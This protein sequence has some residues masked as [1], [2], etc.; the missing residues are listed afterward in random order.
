MKTLVSV[1][2]TNFRSWLHT[3]FQ[4]TDGQHLIV[5][6][7]GTGKSSLLLAVYWCLY[8]KLPHSV[9]ADEVIHEP[10]G[11]DT[12]VTVTLMD[13]NEEYRIT[14]YRKHRTWKNK[15]VIVRDGKR[16]GE[17]D[18]KV[19]SIDDAIVK[20]VGLTA[21]EFLKVVYFSQRDLQRFPALTDLQQKQLLESLTELRVIPNV[22]EL[23]KARL[24]T[25]SSS[26]D[27]LHDRR[28]QHQEALRSYQQ[29]IDQYRK[30]SKRRQENI[31]SEIRHYRSKLHD[32]HARI[33]AC[34]TDL[35]AITDDVQRLEETIVEHTA[36]HSVLRAAAKK[37]T[38][39][40]EKARTIAPGTKCHWCTS[41]LTKE[42]CEAMVTAI[43]AELSTLT[44]R[45]ATASE[46][47]KA[48]QRELRIIDQKKL[49]RELEKAKH[50]LVRYRSY[51][52][53]KKRELVT[54]T[55][56]KQEVDTSAIEAVKVKLQKTKDYQRVLK[57]S[58][59]HV[60]L[61]LVKMKQIRGQMLPQILDEL[62]HRIN[63][64]IAP[65]KQQLE[66]FYREEKGRIRHSYRRGKKWVSYRSLSGGQQQIVDLASSFATWGLTDVSRASAFDCVFLDE[67]L[68]GL[69]PK[70]TQYIPQLLKMIEK[71][72][73]YIISH[74][75]S[76]KPLFHH[77]ITVNMRE[78]SSYIE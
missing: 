33:E 27:V 12:A 57:T 59:R 61:L 6:D 71:K 44:A 73:V 72:K 66:A 18:S 64:F 54:I 11:R 41:L 50:Q 19:A 47:I 35:S 63:K 24:R 56:K 78:R 21:D 30:H 62:T 49:E 70:M 40:L 51:I 60:K 4:F 5:G 76:L 42:T 10:T 17:K 3:K 14:R 31:Q 28:V 39:Q 65:F 45:Q 69:S 13:D 37:L 48:S 8:G 15:A 38:R 1:E 2:L 16:F 26:L 36:E 74:S 25:L 20:L 46:H 9:Q 53:Q 7:I 77:V 22:N 55:E 68:E 29:L 58:R 75:E 43:E 67:P 32:V 23:A 52:K 34:E